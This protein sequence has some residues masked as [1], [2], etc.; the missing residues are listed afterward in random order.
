MCKHQFGTINFL[1]IAGLETACQRA[2][3]GYV[4]VTDRC[5]GAEQLGSAGL[6]V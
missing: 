6:L 1:M 2:P 3:F 5:L 4:C